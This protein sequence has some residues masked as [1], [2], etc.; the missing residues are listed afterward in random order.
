M[1]RAE[2]NDGGATTGSGEAMN[3]ELV[4]TITSDGL[5]LNGALRKPADGQSSQLGVDV[6]VFHHGVAGNFYK[7]SFIDRI[8]DELLAAGCAVLR[9]NN[10]GHDIAYNPARVATAGYAQTVADRR[11]HGPLG[12]AYE[13]VEESLLDWRAWI[14]FGESAGY[15]RIALWG[16]SLGAVKTIYYLANET[17]DRVRCA[18]ASSPP[19]QRYSAYLAT[20]KADELT[21]NMER[22]KQLIESGE[23]TALMRVSVPNPNVFTAR[24]YVDKYGPEE[25]CD[26][27][28]YIPNVRLPMLITLGSLEG[29]TAD[30]A[31]ALPMYGVAAEL[32]RAVA[33]KPNLQFNLIDGADHF[34]TGRVPALWAVAQSW[35]RRVAAP[36][37]VR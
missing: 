37:A 29:A 14:D 6:V 35:L 21:A 5:Y 10:R 24:G 22:A 31:D 7:R 2:L 9:V 12:A 33:P 15:R 36:E 13:V 32:A 25:R 19:R 18:V 27:F 28:K 11:E 3:V 20:N 34:Y 30:S 26:I 17:D 1:G 23:P 16:H 8:G 4:T